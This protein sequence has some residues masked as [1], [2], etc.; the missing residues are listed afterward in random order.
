MSKIKEYK[1]LAEWFIKKDSL[2]HRISTWCKKIN[3]DEVQC[4]IC[5]KNICCTKKGFAALSQH[6]AT[7]LH[8]NNVHSKLDCQQL[9]LKPHSMSSSE[10]ATGNSASQLP[11]DGTSAILKLYNATETTTKAELIWTMKSVQC[12][13][14][15]S[16]GDDLKEV[17]GAMF[18]GAVPDNFHLGRTKLT[19]LI[20]EALGPYFRDELISDLNNSPYS[21][22]YDETT[23]NAGKKEL[24]LVL[25]YW[26]D[27]QRQVVCKY[28]KS[29]FLGHA[30]ANVIS[31]EIKNALDSLS[32][33]KRNMIMIGSD[34]PNVNKKVWRTI[35][36]EL[37]EERGHGLIDVGTCNLHT[38]HN[39]FL[40]GLEEFGETGTDLVTDVYQFFKKYP[41][42][43]EDF[44]NVQNK[45]GSPK[46]RF[47]KHVSSRWL[48]L[49]S[50]TQRLLEQWSS[51]EEYFFKFI[52]NKEKN[53]MQTENINVFLNA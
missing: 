10:S 35:N 53:I 12:N 24:Q 41:S 46:H 20:T 38:V 16:V 5:N 8:K 11:N 45:V 42:R 26:S 17:F 50:A 15:S 18:V 52:P 13:M 39:A 1:I 51:L 33:H 47:L 37:I 34:G 14:A 43:W 4:F 21:L 31:E 49:G 36:D 40:R 3:D 28:L 2:G 29:I 48:T 30:T 23:N 32:L 22:L 7:S 6:V 9:V 44:E 25:R 27:K 19:Y